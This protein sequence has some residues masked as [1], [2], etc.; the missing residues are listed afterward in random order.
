MADAHVVQQ[1]QEP[2][3]G[4]REPQGRLPKWAMPLL[5]AI[6][7]V[8]LLAVS[9]ATWA[10]GWMDQEDMEDWGYVGVFVTNFLPHVSLFIPLPGMTAVGHGL[11][12]WGAEELNPVLVVIVGTIAMTTAEFTSYLAGL[13]GRQTAESQQFSVGG[14][15][16]EWLKGFWG[17]LDRFMQRA[18]YLTLFLL[19]AVPNPFFEFTGITAGALRMNFQLFT[20]A[21]GL[22]HL[23]RIVLLVVLG[24][25]LL[26]AVGL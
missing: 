13:T 15:P 17:W 12:I 1:E 23:V 4:G 11:I 16:G 9:V 2:A 22:G 26:D 19:S 21:V 10:F 14:R 25:E 20:L 24:K 3:G 18:G 5:G 6:V 7:L 8:V